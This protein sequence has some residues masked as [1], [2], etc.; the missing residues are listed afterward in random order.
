MQLPFAIFL[1]GVCG[2]TSQILLT[3]ELV[4]VFYG[5]ELIYGL[6]LMFWL[7]L[8]AFGSMV[9]GRISDKFNRPGWFALTQFLVMFLLPFEIFFT[10]IMKPFFGISTGAIPDLNAI[11]LL[12]FLSLFPL[13]ATLGFQFALGSRLLSERSEAD[14]GKQVG[15]AYTFEALGWVAAGF[16]LSLFF[17]Q[18]LNAFEIVSAVIV[19][20]AVSLFYSLKGIPRYAAVLLAVIV[21]FSSPFLESRSAR[22]QFP[23][24]ELL[25]QSDSSFGRIQIIKDR[26]SISFYENGGLLFSSADRLGNEELIH[27]S[28]LMHW[29]P[30]N[31]LL[32]GGGLGGALG[33][34]DKYRS[35]TTDYLE[36][37]PKVIVLAKKY[38]NPAGLSDR[39][40]VHAEDGVHYLNSENK[41]YD[42][43]I[44]NLPDPDTL[45]VNRYYTSE[46]FKTC[47]KRLNPDGILC[48]KLSTSDTY[49]GRELK[50][51]NQSVLLTL[52]KVFPRVL[53]IPGNYNY[54]FASRATI[55]SDR[56]A[57]IG[58]WKQ[59]K[60]D[61]V[62]FKEGVLSY[63]LDPARIDFTARSIKPVPDTRQ[64]FD[65]YPISYFLSILYWD[66]RFGSHYYPLLGIEWG[67]ALIIIVLLLVFLM[68]LSNLFPSIKPPL[69]IFL[70][71]F[72]GMSC[73]ILI[74]N[75]FQALYGYAYQAIA[76]IIT[77]YMLG[78]ALGSLMINLNFS[79]ITKPRTILRRLAI[80]QILFL[81]V[82]SLFIRQIYLP[83]AALVFALPLGM[84]FPLAVKIMGKENKYYGALGGLLYGMDLLGGGLASFLVTIFI[85][86][87]FGFAS[88]LELMFLICA[89]V[90]LII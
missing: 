70:F 38:L 85:F 13:A 31:V 46:F 68:F 79:N 71:S 61:T 78:L 54:F 90:F 3:R 8:Y 6:A 48:L 55:L 1:I 2:V 88:A 56:G 18:F 25:A 87:L 32:I 82:F 11:F 28:F 74:I 34:A 72:F 65:L 81:A 59:R 26:G 27:L 52:N 17:L 33:E 62:Y 39:I 22:A 23:E 41:L 58:R 77:L 73:S 7:I 69:I 16:I 83:A 44:I 42:L 47:L 35:T 9:L 66:S 76:V 64:N 40:M 63:L 36:L 53:V 89:A 29:N 10:R 19:L 37:D 67:T 4:T 12:T 60:I 5:N 21:A 50:L 57:L 86:P 84:A 14:K 75:V 49:Y 51:L 80:A 30:N 24:F 43:I 45:L 20:L 15:L